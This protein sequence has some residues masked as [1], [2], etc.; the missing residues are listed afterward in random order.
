M[1]LNLLILLYI[2][3]AVMLTVYASSQLFLLLIYFRHRNDPV[4]TPPVAVWPTVVVQLPLYNERYVVRRLLDS[5]A[6]MDYPR[7]LLTVQ[8]LD[9]STDETIE[10]TAA[11]VV[12]LAAKGLNIQH[13]RRP[14]RTGY[15][16]GAMAYGM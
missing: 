8:V 4:P 15:K 9:D 5:V 14:E 6:A 1:L 2:L 16:A 3:C 11:K 12:E 13:V 10:I 7:E